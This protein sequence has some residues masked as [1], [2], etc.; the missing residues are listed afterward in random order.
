MKQGGYGLLVNV[1]MEKG[2]P[3]WH[4]TMHKPQYI[5][6][7]PRLCYKLKIQQ[8]NIR[9]TTTI[10]TIQTYLSMSTTVG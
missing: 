3:V 8:I 9:I 6:R 5:K 1:G 7:R 2:P 4:Y 10:G